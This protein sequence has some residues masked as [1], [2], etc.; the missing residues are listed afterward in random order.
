MKIITKERVNELCNAYGLKVD[1]IVEDIMPSVIENINNSI[2]YACNNGKDVITLNVARIIDECHVSVLNNYVK[3]V[4]MG[5][6]LHEIRNSGLKPSSNCWET[7]QI[8]IPLK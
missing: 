6:V 5:R 3:T 1:G 7:F 4:C 2:E 8:E